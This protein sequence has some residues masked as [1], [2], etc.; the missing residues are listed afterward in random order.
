[1]SMCKKSAPR[2]LF[3]IIAL[4]AAI[5]MTSWAGWEQGT[6]ENAAK[7]RYQ[8]EDGTYAVQNPD[9]EQKGQIGV[10]L[11]DRD[12]DQKSVYFF[13]EN[14]WLYTNTQ[15]YDGLG[16]RWIEVNEKGQA[17]EKGQV[18]R[19]DNGSSESTDS[20]LANADGWIHENGKTYYRY[21]NG[22]Y[23][24]NGW[25]W[26]DR[27]MTNVEM[28]YYFDSNGCL[29]KNTSAPDGRKVNNGGEWYSGN[30]E[31]KPEQ[32]EVLSASEDNHV[33][34]QDGYTKGLSNMVFYLLTHTMDENNAKYE[35]EKVTYDQWISDGRKSTS[36]YIKYKGA[37]I[38]AWYMARDDDKNNYYCR[39]VLD[40]SAQRNAIL[41]DLPDAYD[42]DKVKNL[43]EG[44]EPYYDWRGIGG[45]ITSYRFDNPDTY[46]CIRF[47]PGNK[48]KVDVTALIMG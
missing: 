10:W 41:C 26:L 8:F 38:V 39:Q 7:W 16:K 33:I 31:T 27:L 48:I 11:K 45:A 15:L 20:R 6:G 5:R 43:F 9:I 1:M 35:I 25:V 19:S 36:Y 18:V 40:A 2:L 17:L 42:Y 3:A 29:L 37:P 47:D 30:N 21:A 24:K 13:D 4:T 34:S 46:I 22:S 23:A 32:K 14:G 28:C 44:V 12:S